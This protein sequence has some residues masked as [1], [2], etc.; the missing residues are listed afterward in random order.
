L[1]LWFVVNSILVA[2]FAHGKPLETIAGACFP[3]RRQNRHEHAAPQ[4][5]TAE[6]DALPYATD[7]YKRDLQIERITCR[8]SCIRS[9]P[10]HDA[11][12]SGDV[13]LLHVAATISGHAWRTRSVDNVVQEV[14]TPWNTSRR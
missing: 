14:K 1:I 13:H 7:T 10:L 5:H 12:L 2:E 9:S 6:L 3:Q 8:F 11:R 4:L